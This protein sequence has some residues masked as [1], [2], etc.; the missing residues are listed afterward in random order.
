MEIYDAS[1]INIWFKEW[2]SPI[3]S[4]KAKMN[5]CLFA[6][7]SYALA[8]LLLFCITIQG[9][10]LGIF[11][12]TMPANTLGRWS[13]FG[14]KTLLLKRKKKKRLSGRAGTAQREPN[15]MGMHEDVLWCLHWARESS[16]THSCVLRPRRGN[17]WKKQPHSA[18]CWFFFS[19]LPPPINPTAEK[20]LSWGWKMKIQFIVLLFHWIVVLFVLLPAL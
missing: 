11:F 2:W 9:S 17:G 20:N 12:N 7:N 10:F 18:S 13:T 16:V 14:L 4:L 6:M 1:V 8:C 5:F 3:S 19:P 15:G